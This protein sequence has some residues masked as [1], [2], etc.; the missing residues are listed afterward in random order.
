ML[1]LPTSATFRLAED[2][3]FFPIELELQAEIRV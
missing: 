2:A 3:G 1:A